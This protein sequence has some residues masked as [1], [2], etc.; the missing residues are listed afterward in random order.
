MKQSFRGVLERDGTAL[1]WI[2]VRI[3]FN[4]VK[5]WPIRAGLRVTGAINN[6]PLRTS[7]FGTRDGGHILLINKRV[8]KGAN[9][10]EGS[11]VEVTLEPDLEARS[12]PPPPELVKILKSDRSLKKWFEQLSYSMR[13]DIADTI[14]EPKSP[15]ARTRR[16]EQ[17][18]EQML[19]AMDGEHELPPVLQVAFR[20]QPLAYLG[21]DAMTSI[22][23]RSHLLGIFHYQSAES[24]AKR[25]AKAVED[26][27]RIAARRAPQTGYPRKHAGTPRKTTGV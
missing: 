10:T 18:A 24:R 23:R 25:A 17:L 19:L 22:Q 2:V 12:A 16:A 7:L 6:F 3:P 8:Q 1:R 26:S 20:R 14:L 15:E 13:K 11:I 5:A 9:V 21:W 4:P 27:L